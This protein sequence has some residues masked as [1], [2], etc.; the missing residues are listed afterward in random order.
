MGPRNTLCKPTPCEQRSL[1]QLGGALFCRCP[2]YCQC[3][4]S[5]AQKQLLEEGH[6]RTPQGTQHLYMVLF[7]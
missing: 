3:L 7:L 5:I 4:C 1:P 2:A 6:D